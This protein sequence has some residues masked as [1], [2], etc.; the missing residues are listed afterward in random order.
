[1]SAASEMSLVELVPIVNM[2]LENRTNV[3]RTRAQLKHPHATTGMVA[4]SDGLTYIRVRN[5][6]VQPIENTV[7]S[8]LY[9]KPEP[10]V[11]VG[12]REWIRDT[13]EPAVRAEFTKLCDLVKTRQDLF[14]EQNPHRVYHCPECGAEIIHDTEWQDRLVALDEWKEENRPTLRSESGHVLFWRSTHVKLRF[15]VSDLNRLLRAAD[16]LGGAECMYLSNWQIRLE[17]ED[18]FVV[19]TSHSW[20][21]FH[22]VLKFEVPESVESLFEKGGAE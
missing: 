19:A 18:W 7:D 8:V 21:S 11:L 5:R 22:D 13:L 10:G 15:R 12:G 6:C 1:M 17:G 3:S 9:L 2:F 14:D 4:A 20:G 16:A